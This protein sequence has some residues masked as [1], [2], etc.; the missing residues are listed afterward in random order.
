M[1]GRLIQTYDRRRPVDLVGDPVDARIPMTPFRQSTALLREAGGLEFLAAYEK[2]P[3]GLRKLLVEALVE[4]GEPAQAAVPEILTV[5]A[6]RAAAASRRLRPMMSPSPRRRCEHYV[7]VTLALSQRWYP[8][9]CR[10]LPRAETAHRGE[11]EGQRE[12]GE[13]VD[14]HIGRRLLHR[15]R[16]LGLTQDQV[17]VAIGVRF[18]QVQKYECAANRIFAS[19]LWRIAEVLD[20]PVTYFFEGVER[21]APV[22]P[23]GHAGQS[24]NDPPSRL[25]AK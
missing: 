19:R 18:Q 24:A 1:T 25:S 9:C 12:M 17:A 5:K 11:H 16:A 15:R 3:P 4:M 6:P 7:A 8:A 2:A 22:P 14:E 13:T 21:Q 20:V 23:N 10:T